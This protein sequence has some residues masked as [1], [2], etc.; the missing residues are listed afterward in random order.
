MEIIKQ[1]IAARRS[2]NNEGEASFFE[3]LDFSPQ[4]IKKEDVF[5]ISFSEEPDLLSQ[6][7][8]YTPKNCGYSIGFDSPTLEDI[9]WEIDRMTLVKCVYTESAKA[10]LIDDL[11]NSYLSHWREASRII[12]TGEE[13]N[14][15]SIADSFAVRVAFAASA[16]KDETF[17][18]EREWRLV[19]ANPKRRP[20]NF[21]DGSSFLI[22]YVKFHWGGPKAVP[23][24]QPIVAI[25][26]GPGPNQDLALKAVKML[27]N[28]NQIQEIEPTRSEIPY[29][30]W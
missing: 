26:V 23:P 1:A 6:W 14:T 13:W 25:T 24:C 19:G 4:R 11:L 16:M 2:Q 9:G 30:T 15:P 17:S 27:L 22:P 7:R 5:V 18:E 12:E 10:E 28:A 3:W 21:R 29:R 8:G 20:L